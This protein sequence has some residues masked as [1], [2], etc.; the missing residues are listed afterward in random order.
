MGKY[1]S[2]NQLSYAYAF[3]LS[4]F[5]S[6]AVI[7]LLMLGFGLVGAIIIIRLTDFFRT[8]VAEPSASRAARE[9]W[10]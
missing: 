10:A 9:G 6:A 7:S 4:D 2:L 1:W 8:D 3:E 5:G